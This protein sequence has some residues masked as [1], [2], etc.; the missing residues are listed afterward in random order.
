M[1][2]L[3]VLSLGTFSAAAD[4]TFQ[5]M[6]PRKARGLWNEGYDVASRPVPVHHYL[7]NSSVDGSRE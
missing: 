3:A 7:G 6:V 4:Y 5:E 2:R 1:T